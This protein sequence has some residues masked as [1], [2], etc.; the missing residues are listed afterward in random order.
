MGFSQSLLRVRKGADNLQKTKY[1]SVA[2]LLRLHSKSQNSRYQTQWNYC[3]Y[4]T[5]TI[6]YTLIR[7]KYAPM[8]FGGNGEILWGVWRS[9]TWWAYCWWCY[10]LPNSGNGW[11]Q[12]SNKTHR[13]CPP[14]C[15]FQFHWNYLNLN[16]ALL[17]GGKC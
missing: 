14:F 4:I 10:G 9:S 17:R 8:L 11:M 5:D 15:I 3:R 2:D 13:L 12:D 16:R 6:M 1:Q 7:K